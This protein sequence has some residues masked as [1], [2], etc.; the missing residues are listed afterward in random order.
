MVKFLLGF[1]V[2]WFLANKGYLTPAGLAQVQSTVQP[3]TATALQAVQAAAGA[4]SSTPL[5]A[6]TT[7]APLSGYVTR[8]AGPRYPTQV[9]GW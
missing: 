5:A 7:T 2:A 6:P 3:L 8:G 9:G 4:S 1:G